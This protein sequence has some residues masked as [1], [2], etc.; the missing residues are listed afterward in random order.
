VPL[1]FI[2]GFLL[3]GLRRPSRVVPLLPRGSTCSRRT[4]LTPSAPLAPRMAGCLCPPAASAHSHPL[5]AQQSDPSELGH[6][7]ACTPSFCIVTPPCRCRTRG[8][9]SCRAA[10][11]RCSACSCSS[12]CRALASRALARACCTRAEP[13]PSHRV[14]LRA[15]Q[16]LH[17]PPAPLGSR[18]CVGPRQLTP[19]PLARSALAPPFHVAACLH[20]AAPRASCA[21]SASAQPAACPR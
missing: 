1:D 14:Y 9:W 11:A 12:A 8:P 5:H 6:T 3:N 2:R 10:P 18:A 7:R 17:T 16:R 4:H 13:R 20:C 19:E 15:S 21:L